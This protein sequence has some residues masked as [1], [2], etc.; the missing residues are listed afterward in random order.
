MNKSQPTDF[1]DRLREAREMRSLN[2]FGEKVAIDGGFTELPVDP[3]EIA[4][5]HEIVVQAKPDTAVGV[6]GLLV[7][8]GD[9]FGI[10]YATHID[11]EGFQR[12]SVAHELG[13]YFLDGH[14]EHVLRDGMHESRAGFVTGDPFELEADHFAAGRGL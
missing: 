12:F 8:H 6:S 7:R 5:R 14:P 2:Q 3:F 10:L 1:K 9:T 11:N 13:H 4:A